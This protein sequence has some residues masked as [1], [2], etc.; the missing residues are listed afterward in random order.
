VWLDAATRREITKELALSEAPPK[1]ELQRVLD[2]HDEE[3]YWR[4]KG[5][6]AVRAEMER[7]IAKRLAKGRGDVAVAR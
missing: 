2:A 7:R 1:T 6:A 4:A 3:H 5:E